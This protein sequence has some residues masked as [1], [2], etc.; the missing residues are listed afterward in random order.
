MV[1]TSLQT[2]QSVPRRKGSVDVRRLQRRATAQIEWSMGNALKAGDIGR[3][4][5]WSTRQGKDMRCVVFW[6]SKGIEATRKH[7][8]V[9]CISQTGRGICFRNRRLLVQVQHA[10]T[11]AKPSSAQGERCINLDPKGIE[12]NV[13]RKA[14]L[15]SDRKIV[16][17]KS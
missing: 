8:L 3:E 14:K 13:A 9:G 16:D 15:V 4:N 5:P 7:I 6:S 17:R 2:N 1:P 12:T 11:N 10:L